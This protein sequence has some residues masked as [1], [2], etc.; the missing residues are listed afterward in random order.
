LSIMKLQSGV[1]A[2]GTRRRA[3]PSG[4]ATLA[5]ERRLRD[6]LEHARDRVSRLSD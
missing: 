4:R 6:L 5:I 1:R 2:D 3:E